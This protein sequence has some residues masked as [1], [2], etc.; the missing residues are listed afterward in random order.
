MDTFLEMSEEFDNLT[1]KV[2]LSMSVD[3]TRLQADTEFKR[4]LIK[5]I[6]NR[7]ATI[8]IEENIDELINSIDTTDIKHVIIKK[9]LESYGKL[10]E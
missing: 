4:E 1:Q 8:F 2:K 5:R 10:G 7:V 9:T 6:I 3:S